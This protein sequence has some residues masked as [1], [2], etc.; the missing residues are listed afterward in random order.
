M[1]E[2]Q[3]IDL[4]ESRF[5]EGMTLL[6]RA[7]FQLYEDR[8]CMPWGIF[9]EA[10]EATIGRSVW[11]HEFSGKE[12][13]RRLQAELLFLY[14]RSAPTPDELIAMIPADKRHIVLA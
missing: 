11:T 2:Q 13:R 5:W 1:T 12:G 10:T 14:G 3:A 4:C 8:L 9:H 6:E 7:T